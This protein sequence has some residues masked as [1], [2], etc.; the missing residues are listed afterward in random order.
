[1]TARRPALASVLAVLL[2]TFLVRPAPAA[3]PGCAAVTVDADSDV[4]ERYPELVERIRSDLASRPDVDACARVALHAG[5]AHTIYVSVT[6]ADGR[7]ATRPAERH[8]DVLPTLQ[9]LLIIPNPP[10]AL[11]TPL[12]HKAAVGPL[13]AIRS[14]AS[15]PLQQRAIDRASP[16]TPNVAPR[17]LGFELSLVGGPRMG[18]GQLGLG[19][20]ALSFLEVHG[21]LIGF[22]SRVDRYQTLLDGD[23]EM[24]LELAAL[25]GRRLHFRHFALDLNAGPAVAMK[26]LALGSGDVAVADGEAARQPPPFPEDP[27]TGPVPRLLLNVRAGFSPRSA[28]RSFAGVEASIGPASAEE[29]I[30]P[31]QSHF[32][33]FILGLVVGG[34]VGTR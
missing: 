14:F 12:S 23:P 33:V 34:T 16:L 21:W 3:E 20:G 17:T 22:Q 6:L 9:A 26:G 13:P 28:L 11:E 29:S 25:A 10:P 4:I 19:L 18:E 32:P 8:E 15:G 31:K 30:R 24:G 2:A 27:S 7:S 1:M 5:P